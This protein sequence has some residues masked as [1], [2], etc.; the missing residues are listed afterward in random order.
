LGL[1]VERGRM[2]ALPD[3][4]SRAARR[5][6]H[7]P[8]QPARAWLWLAGGALA[9]ALLMAFTAAR[10]RDLARVAEAQAR[11]AADAGRAR[12]RGLPQSN[13][14]SRRLLEWRVQGGAHASLAHVLAALEPALSS[15]A[16][17]ERITV[18]YGEHIAVSLDVVARGAR[19]Y[20]RFVE[21]LAALPAFAD[22]AT[23]PENRDGEV[24][25]QVRARYRTVPEP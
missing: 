8:R 25:A 15:D 3:F 20:D 22:V 5:A 11:R 9:V 18:D 2:S 13:D 24:R 1:V 16:R 19:D 14:P 17:L 6:A 12:L 23:G 10:T 21:R 7:G 4:S